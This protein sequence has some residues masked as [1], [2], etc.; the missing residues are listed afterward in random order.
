MDKFDMIEKSE[1][2]MSLIEQL[3]NPQYIMGGALD[4]QYTIALMKRASDNIE[5]LNITFNELQKI[6]L[7]MAQYETEN[8]NKE[9]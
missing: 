8:K 7:R 6:G 4:A 2:E 9:D 3:R 5:G 1:N